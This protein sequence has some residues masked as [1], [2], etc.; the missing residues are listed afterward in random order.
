MQLFDPATST[1]LPQ[2]YTLPSGTTTRVEVVFF[3]ADGDNIN[4]ELVAGHFASLTFDPATFATVAGV[5]GEK[6]LFDVLVHADPGT[7]AAATVG[8]GHDEQADERSFGPYTVTA[9]EGAPALRS[10]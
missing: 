8:Y 1:A 10:R 3:N 6:F 9:S 7:A 5:T 2:P 4:S